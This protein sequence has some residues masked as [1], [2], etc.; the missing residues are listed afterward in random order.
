MVKRTRLTLTLILPLLLLLAGCGSTQHDF[1][2]RKA[3]VVRIVDNVVRKMQSS[4][5]DRELS[6]INTLHT[7]YDNAS[8]RVW[9][10]DPDYN[11]LASTSPN[12]RF[13]NH[14]EKRDDKGKEYPKKIII[15]ATGAKRGNDG[16][17][18]FTE[19]GVRYRAF[20]KLAHARDDLYY[21]VVGA[22]P[23]SEF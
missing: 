3:E 17:V 11:V 18:N 22:S 2:S 16:W 23:S 12:S 9:V 14:R 20:Y 1:D 6:K 13:I 7:P 10:Y 4:E 15:G 19:N 5:P 21:I 8:I